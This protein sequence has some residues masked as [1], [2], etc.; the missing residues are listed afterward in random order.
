MTERTERALSA[1][2]LAAEIESTLGHLAETPPAEL[3]AMIAKVRTLREDFHNALARHVEPVLNEY[4]KT[5]PQS[6]VEE[7]RVLAK[8]TNFLL[9][10]VGLAL[11]EGKSG[12][13]A[14]LRTDVGH[15]P[16]RGRFQLC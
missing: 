13:D 6:T 7:K 15:N 3:P 16:E 1:H 4:V 10:S 14:Y 2:E 11:R 8:S 12:E 9:R 5:L